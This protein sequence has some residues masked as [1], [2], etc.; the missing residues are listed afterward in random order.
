[1]YGGSSNY[2]VR[3][4]SGN[5]SATKRTVVVDKDGESGN[6][7]S[8]GSHQMGNTQTAF[9]KTNYF[10]KLPTQRPQTQQGFYPNSQNM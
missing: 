7:S 3:S 2:S 6:L 8:K 4:K 5:I 9:N 10:S 1:M